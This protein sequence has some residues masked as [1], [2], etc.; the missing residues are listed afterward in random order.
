M[1]PLLTGEESLRRLFAALTEHTFQV[2]LGVVD[3][4]LSDYLVDMLV[5]FTRTPDIY[6]HRDAEGLPESC[7]HR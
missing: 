4:G 5:R 1:V 3:P 2:E 6:R 7:R